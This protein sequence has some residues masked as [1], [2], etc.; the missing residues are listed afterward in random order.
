[1][2]DGIWT[3]L[4]RKKQRISHNYFACFSNKNSTQTLAYFYYSPEIMKFPVIEINE[5]KTIYIISFNY[6]NQFE[7]TLFVLFNII[8]FV[9]CCALR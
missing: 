3:S 2:L 4:R 1:M 6:K 9:L 5:N 8:P 7:A